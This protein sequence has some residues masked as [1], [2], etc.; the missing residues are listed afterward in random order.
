MKL[1][2]KIIEISAEILVAVFIVFNGF[3]MQAVAIYSVFY[4]S[5]ALGILSL[6]VLVY[7]VGLVLVALGFWVYFSE[8]YREKIFEEFFA[9]AAVPA[10]DA[11]REIFDEEEAEE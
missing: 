8:K 1:K 11:L 5:F 6:A 4:A 7:I 2:V 9:N 10:R 3:L